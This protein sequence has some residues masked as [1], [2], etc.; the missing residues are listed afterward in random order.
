MEFSLFF[1]KTIFF[2]N[3]S[4][5]NLSGVVAKFGNRALIIT[6]KTSSRKSGALEKV[7]RILD[8]KNIKYEVFDDIS[9]EP[10]FELVDKIKS[11][12]KGID[13]VIG[14]G[15]GSALDTA[16]AV[17][18]VYHGEK[19]TREYL[20]KDIDP[21][22]S[23]SF[24]AITTTSGSGSE[25]TLNAVLNDNEKGNKYSIA[26][27]HF[28][29]SVSIVDPVLTYSIPVGTTVATG[30]DALT[31]ALE[32]YT[33]KA[34][35]PVTMG[36]ALKATELICNNIIRLAENIDDHEAREK[37]ALGSMTAALAFSQTGVGVAHS[38]S[39][40]LG[41]IFKIPHGV[42]NAIL[43]PKVVK[44]NN[45]TCLERYREIA[46][47]LGIEDE[48]YVYLEEL[49]SKLPLPK[50]LAEAG[51]K[52]GYEEE[53]LKKTFESRSITKNPREVF[54]T[55]VLDIINECL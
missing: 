20:G 9:E 42:I 3:D 36:L 47:F 4:V 25:I 51:Y 19:S 46:D 35:N 48:L 10:D 26:S 34:A 16:K 8:G 50:G 17:A 21:E 30:M 31:H 55:D 53:I 14:I 39:H 22:I 44:Y 24:I 40:P 33:S 5:Q 6:G 38:I 29:A 45:E 13:F 11:S 15:G 23:V 52:K 2:G 18:G 7:S 49:T 27:P 32:S 28:Q 12:K 41:A 43:I 54:D 37:M 1:P